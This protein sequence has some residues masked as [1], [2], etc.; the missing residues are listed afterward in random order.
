MNQANL[1]FTATRT[2]RLASLCGLAILLAALSSAPAQDPPPT[3]ENIG[4]GDSG[5]QMPPIVIPVPTPED[6]ANDEG[7]TPGEPNQGQ[8][9]AGPGRRGDQSG[10]TGHLA[11]G[12]QLRDIT[13][14]PNAWRS[15]RDRRSNRGNNYSR[16]GG[17][18]SGRSSSTETNL[19]PVSMDYF[20]LIAQRNIFDPNRVPSVERVQRVSLPSAPPPPPRETLMLVG[21]ISYEDGDY[22]FFTG[23]SSAYNATLKPADRIAGYKIIAVTPNSVKLAQNTNVLE[24]AIGEQLRREENGPWHLSG[25]LP[26]D[27]PMP[28]ANSSSSGSTAPASAAS[29]AAPAAAGADSDIIKRMMQRRDQE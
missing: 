3:D 26:P 18:G 21:T 16:S 25:A 9:S 7:V 11:P 4:N 20:A 6:G 10:Q 27:A 13:R 5:S 14:D 1:L 23:S 15:Q 19:S 2:A 8:P 28:E 24:L 12:N 29:T 22:A 17:F